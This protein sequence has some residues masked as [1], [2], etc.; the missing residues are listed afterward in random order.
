[1]YLVSVETETNDP[2][3]EGTI[4]YLGIVSSEERAQEMVDTYV[5]EGEDWQKRGEGW[6]VWQKKN[7]WGW[8]QAATETVGYVEVP[9]LD[10]TPTS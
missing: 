7:K 3:D 1:M 10:S 8:T 9:V 5:P 6:W 2:D 4:T